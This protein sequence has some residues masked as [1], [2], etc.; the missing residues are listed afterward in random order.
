[1]GLGILR[2]LL[3][4]L[5]LSALLIST[6]IMLAGPSATSLAFE[7]LYAVATGW[8]GPLTPAWPPTMDSELR[9]YAPLFAAFGVV[10]LMVARNPRGRLGLTPWLAGVFFAGGLGRAL[11]WSA[12]GAP[13]PLFLVLMTIELVTPPVLVA[14]WWTQRDDQV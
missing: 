2:G 7:H 1:M 14:L 4:T 8:R 9:F 5:G 12:V 11:S 13:H 3:A 6:A 10:A